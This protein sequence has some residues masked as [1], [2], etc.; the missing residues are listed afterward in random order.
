MAL[1]GHMIL[2]I[3]RWKARS[4]KSMLQQ[5]GIWYDK[6]PGTLNL[7]PTCHQMTGQDRLG[8]YSSVE[9]KPTSCLSANT[10]RYVC[11]V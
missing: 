3:K 1:L 6:L 8:V 9:S 11:L 10:L 7:W 2:G 5:I 4:V